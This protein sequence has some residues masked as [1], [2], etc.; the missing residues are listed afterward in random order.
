M[1]Y[2]KEKKVTLSFSVQS[3]HNTLHYVLQKPAVPYQKETPTKARISHSAIANHSHM[4]VIGVWLVE[5]CSLGHCF[6][7]RASISF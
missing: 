4:L 1:I 6:A 2:T 5:K 7:A 3:E